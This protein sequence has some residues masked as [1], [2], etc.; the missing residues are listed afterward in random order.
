MMTF[1][2]VNTIRRQIA[3]HLAILDVKAEAV[4]AI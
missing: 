2:I 1:V 3:L 4:T